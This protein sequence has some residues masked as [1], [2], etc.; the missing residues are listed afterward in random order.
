MKSRVAW[1]LASFCLLLIL[2][3]AAPLWHLHVI[4]GHMPFRHNDLIGRWI[5]ARAALQGQDPYSREV[6]RAMQ[7]AYYGRPLTPDDRLDAQAFLYPATIV[8]P[9]APLTHFSWP[10]ASFVF[11]ILTV[12]LLI[13]GFDLCLRGLPV[14]FTRTQH[15]L[16]ILLAFFSWPTLWGLRLLQP[17][18]PLAALVLI[19]GFLLARGQQVLPAV[20]LACT[21]IKPQL[22]LPLILWLLLW[23][24]LQ[25]SWKFIASFC[26]MLA[27][28]L[29]A[30]HQVVP[31]WFA[32]WRAS[33][34]NYGAVTL[35]APPLEWVFGHWI[36]FALTVAMV[37]A[38]GLLLWRLLRAS[39]Q[40]AEFAVAFSLLLSLTLCLVPTHLA[41]VYN[42]IL[43]FPGLMILLV[44]R[45]EGYYASLARRIT[46]ALCVFAFATPILAIAGE[47]FFGPSDFWDGIPCRLFLLPVVVTIALALQAPE[48]LPRR[49]RDRAGATSH[50]L[51]PTLTAG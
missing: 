4:D 28:L 45:P 14:P 31:G 35:S 20:L 5:G 51:E 24:G 7:T 21:T 1:R 26:A 32:H 6:L 3:L 27:L 16:A 8:L 2:V 36:G 15:N 48:S 38:G 43:L 22:V 39:A 11:L 41:M 47:S 17:T 23:A 13:L 9:L 37:V 50:S 33:L 19:A 30:T 29:W 18:L 42:Q 40:S 49:A 44:S 46:L 10:T 12:L 34:H 25:R